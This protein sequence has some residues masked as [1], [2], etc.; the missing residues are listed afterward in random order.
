MGSAALVPI[1][2]GTQLLGMLQ[3]FSAQS[4]PPASQVMLSLEAV[5]LQL[6]GVARLLNAA[7]TPHW[8]YGRL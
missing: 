1:S 6:A 5:A 2:D 3:L 4:E 8:R 7:S